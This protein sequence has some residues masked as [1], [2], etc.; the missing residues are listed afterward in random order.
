MVEKMGTEAALWFGVANKCQ[1]RGACPEEREFFIDNP[2][3][4]IH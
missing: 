3:V 4:Q 2:L 1:N